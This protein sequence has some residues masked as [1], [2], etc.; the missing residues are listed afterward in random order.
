MTN[1]EIWGASIQ[2]DLDALPGSSKRACI[3]RV[4]NLLRQVNK[5]AYTPTTVSIGPLHYKGEENLQAMQVYKLKYFKSFLQDCNTNLNSCL[6][7]VKDKE[8]E[9]RECYADSTADISSE[10]FTRMIL[11]DSVFIIEFFRRLSK[12]LLEKNYKP[13]SKP[14]MIYAVRRDIRLAENQLLFFILKD[15]Y[16]TAFR[17]HESD[18]VPY[19]TD[20]V[21]DSLDVDKLKIDI[22]GTTHEAKC[23]H[24][25]DLLR[26]YHIPSK[27]KSSETRVVIEID[28]NGKTTLCPTAMSLYEADVKFRVADGVASIC[29]ILLMTDVQFDDKKGILTIPKLEVRN[30]TESY[31][32]NLIAFEQCH[33]LRRSPTYLSDYLLFLNCLIYTPQDVHVLGKKHIIEN[34]LGSDKYVSDLVN[35]MGKHVVVMPN[36]YYYANI[37]EKL[38][39]HCNKRSNRYKAALKHKYFTHP[40]AV[41]SVIY[42]IIILILTVMQVVSEIK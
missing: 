32:R 3:Y 21:C 14:Y 31:S 29:D 12:S 22:G 16:W 34:W 23:L 26:T 15:L 35:S 6:Q 10:E 33:Y 5:E 30:R 38:N 40:W 18:D 39:N 8:K 24:L 42:A 41:V 1:V 37:N 19:F 11:F 13:W 25:L 4:P 9:I 20:L 2:E 36:I 17:P 7:V 27:V 28:E